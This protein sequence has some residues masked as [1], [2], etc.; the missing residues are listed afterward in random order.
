MFEEGVDG[1]RGRAKKSNSLVRLPSR[2]GVIL[3]LG[4]DPEYGATVECKTKKRKKC[5]SLE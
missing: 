5:G 1:A 2:G 4:G 3:L